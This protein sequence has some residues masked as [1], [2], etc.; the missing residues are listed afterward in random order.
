MLSDDDQKAA[1]AEIFKCLCK[2]GDSEISVVRLQK[3]LLPNASA[4]ELSDFYLVGLL[5]LF[6]K[7]LCA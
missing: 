3:K 4:S 1:Y 2:D 7:K 6:I 5:S